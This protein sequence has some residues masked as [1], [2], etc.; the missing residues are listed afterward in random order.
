[1]NKLAH[2]LVGLLF[3][4]SWGAGEAPPAFATE[5]TLPA[6]PDAQQRRYLGLPAHATHFTLADLKAEWVVVDVF[7]MYCHVCQQSAPALRRLHDALQQ[8]DMAER[9]RFLGVGLG[10]SPLETSVFARRFKLPF[11]VVP[12]RS[13]QLRKAFPRLRAGTLII[14]HRTDNTC[15]IFER[16]Q[17]L[18]RKKEADKLAQK[19]IAATRKAAAD[20][21]R[22]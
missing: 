5:A 1:M 7:D 10:N 9:I 14:F 16:H 3:F 13:K 18:L 15:R 11:P 8:T 6:P 17:G 4:S 19:I 21:P 2:G 20:S 22:L 12:D